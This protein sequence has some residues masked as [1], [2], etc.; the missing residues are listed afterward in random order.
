M[1]ERLH[2]CLQR[3]PSL[4]DLTSQ[5]WNCFLKTFN[6]ILQGPSP[7]PLFL[8]SQLSLDS[9]A[10]SFTQP[11]VPSVKVLPDLRPKSKSVSKCDFPKSFLNNETPNA[12]REKLKHPNLSMDA[13]LL[14]SILL[15][16][17]TVALSP[18]PQELFEYFQ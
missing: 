8:G 10:P 5:I 2:I 6:L 11:K 1:A 18:L 16:S 15:S 13:L 9:N 4:L 3:F 12:K 7:D 14:G 17:Q